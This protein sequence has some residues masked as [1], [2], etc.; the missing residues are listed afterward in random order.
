MKCLCITVL[1]TAI[2]G[3]SIAQNVDTMIFQSQSVRLVGCGFPVLNYSLLSPL[4]HSGYSLCFLSSRFREKPEHLTQFQMQIKIGVLHNDANDSY[5][6]SL[7]FSGGWIQHWNLTAPAGQL[8][9]MPGVGADAD[10]EVYMKDDNTNNPMAY[11]F[12]MSLTPSVLI[13]YR[14]SINRSVLE[15]KQQ[16]DIPLVSLVSSS[17]YST[18]LPY[19]FMEEEASFFEA[20]RLV[21]FGSLK[22]CA[23]ITTLDIA[24][25]SEQ[26]K[27]WPTLRITYIFTGMNYSNGDFIIKS[28]NNTILFGA[29][30]YLFR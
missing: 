18:S 25:P 7:G 27:K 1:C 13:R 22:K 3:R 30:F 24:Y 19:G 28:V 12:N 29:I 16:I 20:I 14:F 21:S 26:G 15:L 4:N 2:I 6:T 17:E 23:T 9:L 8:R 5:V 10:L 11:F